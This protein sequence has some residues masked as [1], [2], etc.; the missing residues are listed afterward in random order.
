MDGILFYVSYTLI[1]KISFIILYTMYHPFTDKKLE[2]IV[3]EM[4]L[5]FSRGE[6]SIEAFATLRNYLMCILEKNDN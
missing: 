3:F 4:E 6:L 1:Y 5:K 2:E